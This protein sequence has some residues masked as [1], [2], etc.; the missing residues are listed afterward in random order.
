MKLT[1]LCRIFRTFILNVHKFMQNEN[2]VMDLDN[3]MLED[4]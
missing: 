4:L 1:T 3:V 2:I